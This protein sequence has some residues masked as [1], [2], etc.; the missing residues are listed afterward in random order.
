MDKSKKDLIALNIPKGIMTD[1][2]TDKGLTQCIQI[3]ID[4]KNGKKNVN[5]H[6]DFG[7]IMSDVFALTELIYTIANEKNEDLEEIE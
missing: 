4:L 1:E 3:L 7:Y 2:D 5:T 6:E